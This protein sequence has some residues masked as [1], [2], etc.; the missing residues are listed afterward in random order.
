MKPE[1]RRRVEENELALWLAKV[2][3]AVRPYARP[4][5]WVVVI[6]VV[7][8]LGGAIWR[9]TAGAASARASAAFYQALAERNPAALED[10]ARQYSGR[11]SHLARLAAA[12]LYLAAGCDELFRNKIVAQQELQKA[13]EHYRE[14]ERSATDP[15]L[16][17]RA[18]FGMARTYEAM[19]GTRA[20]QGN[21]RLAIS[22]Y[23]E[24][25]RDFPNSPYASFAQD[26]LSE[27]QREEIKA[28]YDRFAQYDP[29][30][31]LQPEP[32]T[33]PLPSIGEVIPPEPSPPAQTDTQ[34]SQ[35]TS[36]PESASTQE[37]PS[38]PILSIP[39]EPSGPQEAPPTDKDSPPERTTS[40][41]S[42]PDQPV[43][44]EGSQPASTSNQ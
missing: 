7:I 13:L 11:V 43:P 41:S 39:A 18:R 3:T 19:A 37:N 23:Q 16:R 27:V 10:V 28:F 35:E 32:P 2:I 20:G 22:L 12:D 21:L 40:E 1:E 25:I 38:G 30:P 36:R 8:L 34:S 44:V 14:V 4:I 5:G 6:G 26:R 15:E 31:E 17:A 9:S 42:S 29:R 33:S 24:V